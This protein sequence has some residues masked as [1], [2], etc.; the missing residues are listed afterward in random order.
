MGRSWFL[1]LQLLTMEYG[2]GIHC[3]HLVAGDGI[4]PQMSG[5]PSPFY[6]GVPKRV[7]TDHEIDSSVAGTI[8]KPR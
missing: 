1:F 8:V 4:S 6:L 7:I 3:R 5:M 2:F